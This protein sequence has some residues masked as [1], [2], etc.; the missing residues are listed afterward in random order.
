MC[1]CVCVCACVR[2]LFSPNCWWRKGCNY[3]AIADI[4]PIFFSPVLRPFVSRPQ[5]IF[6]WLSTAALFGALGSHPGPQT[7]VPT[8][9]RQV[10]GDKG[11]GLDLGGGALLSFS[12]VV[13]FLEFKTTEPAFLHP[14]F[15][16]LPSGSGDGLH[17]FQGRC[18]GQCRWARQN[19]S[20]ARMWPTG[21]SLQSIWS[22]CTVRRLYGSLPPLP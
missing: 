15:H 21:A 14:Q 4:K 11:S 12:M 9:A 6:P 20:E 2:M 13:A 8:G 3:I 22:N 19:M 16:C 5:G 10:T 7:Q 17:L 1:V 18:G